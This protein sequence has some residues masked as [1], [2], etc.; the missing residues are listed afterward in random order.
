MRFLVSVPDLPVPALPVRPLWLR[1]VRARGCCLCAS[2]WLSA[3]GRVA[4]AAR[5]GYCGSTALQQLPPVCP[6]G[7]V[8]ARLPRPPQ[9]CAPPPRQC[10]RP[11]ARLD[12]RGSGISIPPNL[13]SPLSYRITSSFTPPHTLHIK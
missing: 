4:A 6:P 12:A 2:P 11:P 8:L 9:A 5:D 7:C 1:A 10:P 3:E 13:A